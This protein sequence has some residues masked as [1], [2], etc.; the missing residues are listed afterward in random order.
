MAAETTYD[1]VPFLIAVGARLLEEADEFELESLEHRGVRESVVEDGWWGR[2]PARLAEVEELEQRLGTTLPPDYRTFL[3]C[4]NGWNHC[5]SLGYPFGI[6]DLFSTGEVDWFASYDEEI[7][8]LAVYTSDLG[9]DELV[10]DSAPAG[11]LRKSLI[12]GDWDGNECLLLNP[13][14]RSDRGEW[15]L[16]TFMSDGA[17]MD[18]VPSFWDF[19]HA[20]AP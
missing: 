2:E 17:E 13:A 6:C 18:R 1:W 16:I 11:H 7:G 12:I 4:T 5:V 3:L 15:E 19:M 20:Y 14:V 10:W 8:R 9:D